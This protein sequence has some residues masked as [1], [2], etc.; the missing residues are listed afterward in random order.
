[1]RK[2]KTKRQKA[3]TIDKTQKPQTKKHIENMKKKNGEKRQK[4]KTLDK[5]RKKYK[6]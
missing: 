2:T 6:T 1:M 3:K 4:A 5:T